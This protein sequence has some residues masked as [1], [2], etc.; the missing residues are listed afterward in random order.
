MISLNSDHINLI[1]EQKSV[2]KTYL[3]I[4][5]LFDIRGITIAHLVGTHFFMGYG[6]L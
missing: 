2:T 6:A 5:K 4:W 1:D 3:Q